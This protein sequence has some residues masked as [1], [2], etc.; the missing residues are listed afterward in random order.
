MWIAKRTIFMIEKN[1]S[2]CDE[3]MLIYWEDL[4][5]G[6]PLRLWGLNLRN[7]MVI[8]GNLLWHG[9][10]MFPGIWRMETCI[11]VFF[12][13]WNLGIRA[14]VFWGVYQE[15]SGC[16][17]D[18]MPRSP[19]T[20]WDFFATQ[21]GSQATFLRYD[22]G[23]LP[24][25]EIPSTACFLAGAWSVIYLIFLGTHVQGSSPKKWAVLWFP[26]FFCRCP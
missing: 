8:Y 19:C 25:S 24:G 5:P 23:I 1:G 11:Q 17:S 26:L 7:S 3:L 16:W 10:L 20:N 4:V 6:Y 13:E 14:T 9:V 18:G 15:E 12:Q 2:L 21:F 22:P